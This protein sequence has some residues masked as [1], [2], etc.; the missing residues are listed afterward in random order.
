MPH[1]P[2]HP[3][4]GR[5]AR[6]ALHTGAVAEHPS[7]A[8][9]P[10]DAAAYGQRV[11]E[12]PCFVCA[13]LDGHPDYDHPLLYADGT[14]VAFL[15]RY[16]TLL[17][18]SIVAPRRHVEHA[19]A[20]LDLDE[21][22]QLQTVIHRVGRAISAAV[23]TERLY[24]MSLGSQQ[25]NAHLHWHIAPLPPGT[26]YDDQQFHAVMAENGVLDVDPADQEA[27]AA[28]IRAQL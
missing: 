8:R 22:L 24:V 23:P 26:P 25:G 11:H 9:K 19:V 12:G 5:P 6:L 2:S 16:P 28:R 4:S 15:S 27:L 14:V 1:V 17:G 10:F 13:M 21:Y 7:A 18:Y 3:S 20:D